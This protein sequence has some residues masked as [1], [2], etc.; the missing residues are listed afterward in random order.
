MQAASNAVQDHVLNPVEGNILGDHQPR[1][2]PSGRTMQALTWQ[3]ARKVEMKEVPVPGIT[4]D[5]DAIL[6]ITGTT[7]CGSDLH[8]FNGESHLP[9]TDEFLRDSCGPAHEFSV[10][11]LCLLLFTF[12]ALHLIDLLFRRDPNHESRRHPWVSS[13]CSPAKGVSS[14]HEPLAIYVFFFLRRAATNL[15]A[16]STKSD[17]MSRSLRRVM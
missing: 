5:E 3:G 6:R 11:S 2:D 8:L 15:W 17:R 9:D 14:A 10:D 7:I 13:T 16:L 1:P 12:S 4:K